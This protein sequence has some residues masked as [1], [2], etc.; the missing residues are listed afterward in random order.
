MMTIS[1]KTAMIPWWWQ[2]LGA[3]I[4]FL[5]P[6]LPP[7]SS[8]FSLSLSWLFVVSPESENT[9]AFLQFWKILIH[10]LLKYFLTISLFCSSGSSFRCILDLIILSSMF[11]NI[12]SYFS[13]ISLYFVLGNFSHILYSFFFFSSWI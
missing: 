9:C 13:S 4:L 7:Q 8:L 6:S 10:Y 11:F 2:H 3:L 12:A 1:L 5:L